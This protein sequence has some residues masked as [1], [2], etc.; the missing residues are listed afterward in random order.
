MWTG[1]TAYAGVGD[2]LVLAERVRLEELRRRVRGDLAAALLSAPDGDR[3]AEAF[4]IAQALM[5]EHPLDEAAAVLAMRAADR[6]HRQG[7]ALEVF[8]RLRE[9]LREELGVDA[10]EAA[11]REHARILA[12]DAE[13]PPARGCVPCIRGCASR[14]RR[15]RRSAGRRR[16][17]RCC[18]PSRRDVAWSR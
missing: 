2:D 13:A 14:C 12:R 15:R 1:G 9:R 11:V 6:L 8:A 16:W 10:G 3:A 4:G 5:T 17:Q 18:A 7:E